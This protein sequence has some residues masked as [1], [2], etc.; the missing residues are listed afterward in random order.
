MPTTFRKKSRTMHA[1]R[2]RG[3]GV[4]GHRK[5]GMKGGTGLTTGKFK[6]HWTKH[7]QM[8]ALGFPGPDGDK[9]RIGK[10]G[11]IRPQK[12]RRIYEVRPINLKVVDLQ[13]D[14]WVEAGKAEKAGKLYKVDLKALNFNK[15][16]GKGEITKQIEITVKKA[17]GGAIEKVKA[18]K[19]KVILTEEA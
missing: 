18:A 11:F 16:L 19:G 4:R 7:L 13:I 17:S 14:S 9:W 15:L 12:I 2:T 5:K 8:K 6:H 1:N 10:T 3:Y